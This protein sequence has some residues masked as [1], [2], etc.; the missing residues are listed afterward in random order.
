MCKNCT[1]L[2]DVT[3][4]F[5]MRQ[6]FCA[7]EHCGIFSEDLINYQN[8]ATQRCDYFQSFNCFL[9]VCCMHKAFTILF[10][11][12]NAASGVCSNWARMIAPSTA[13]EI[14]WAFC[15]S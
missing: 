10:N 2:I 3:G 15:L 7:S 13:K 11:A 5:P 12:D 1:R 6:D 8:A 4:Y 9:V 14:A